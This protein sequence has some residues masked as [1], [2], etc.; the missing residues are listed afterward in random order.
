MLGIGME[1]HRTKI[2]SNKNLLK[3]PDFASHTVDGV[4]IS[5][6]GGVLTMNGSPG[7]ILRIDGGN[8]YDLNAGANPVLSKLVSGKQYTLGV[9]IISGSIS[10]YGS[11]RLIA[12]EGSPGTLDNCHCQLWST[13]GYT[14]TFTAGNNSGYTNSLNVAGLILYS[15]TCTNWKIRIQLEQST[16]K[17][18]WENG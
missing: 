8:I 14:A 4:T 2:M 15:A 7:G 6:S 5:S 10:Q 12:S 3:F 16:T 17:T 9:D 1:T 18:A 13:P 11:L